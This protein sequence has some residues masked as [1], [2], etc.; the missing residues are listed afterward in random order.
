MELEE[1][2]EVKEKLLNTAQ[3]I[4]SKQQAITDNRA[5]FFNK[6][7]EATHKTR[8][9]WS[10]S[11]DAIHAAFK[12]SP[13]KSRSV[14]IYSAKNTRR[15]PKKEEVR[16]AAALLRH[17]ALGWDVR[18]SSKRDGS[19]FRIIYRHRSVIED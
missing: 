2:R 3:E 19:E 16:A 11:L 1:A 7:L 8:V 15:G 10:E 18:F 14:T 13:Y 17:P 5:D 12:D 4:A 6:L 9:I